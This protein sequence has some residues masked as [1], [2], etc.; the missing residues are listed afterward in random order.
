MYRTKVFKDSWAHFAVKPRGYISERVGRFWDSYHTH[1]EQD[2]PKLHA[3][4][5]AM[6]SAEMR[7]GTFYKVV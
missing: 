4:Y 5:W 7:H 3:E 1:T 2:V 6:V